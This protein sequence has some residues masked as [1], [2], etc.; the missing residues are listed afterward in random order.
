[1]MK[2]ADFSHE[3]KRR[4]VNLVHGD[5]WIEIKERSDV[6]AHFAIKVKRSSGAASN[7]LQPGAASSSPSKLMNHFFA[8]RESPAAILVA[9]TRHS[10]LPRQVVQVG[11]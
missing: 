6:S 5:R 11:N 10:P 7:S 8:T 9:F 2:T 4:S 1:M 3:L